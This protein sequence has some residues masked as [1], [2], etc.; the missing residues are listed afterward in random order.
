LAFSKAIYLL[1][2]GRTRNQI[3]PIAITEI[4][5]Q[6]AAKIPYPRY[7]GGVGIGLVDGGSGAIHGVYDKPYSF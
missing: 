2:L 7:G 4:R 5:S 6:I 3:R 1:I